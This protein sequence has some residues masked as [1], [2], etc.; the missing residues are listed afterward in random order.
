MEQK[1]EKG[2]EEQK[3]LVS[4]LLFSDS[5]AVTHSERRRLEKKIAD[6]K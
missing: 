1:R 2:E 3:R 6:E 4:F 5:S